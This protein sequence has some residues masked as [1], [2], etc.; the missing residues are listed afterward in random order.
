MKYIRN[1][2]TVAFLLVAPAFPAVAQ[3]S[4]SNL[5]TYGTVLTAGQWNQC[6]SQKQNYLNYTPVNK[7]GDVM[8]G[9]LTMAASTTS[10]AGITIS[11]G[12]VPLSPADGQ[13]WITTAGVYSQVNGAVWNFLSDSNPATVTNKTINCSNNTCTIPLS[14]IVTG[15]QDTVLGYF[16]STALSA[17]AVPNCTTAVIYS[18]STHTW[19]CNAAT[20]GTVTSIGLTSTYGLSVSGSP[21]TVSGNISSGVSLTTA[22]NALGADVLLNNTST[23]FDGPSMAQGTTGT[24]LVS[25]SVTVNDGSGAATIYCK[26]WDGTTVINSGVTTVS[27]TSSGSTIALSGILASPA[28]NIRISCRDVTSTNGRIFFNSTGTSRDGVISGIRIQ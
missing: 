3:S 23:Y 1:I 9:A 17:A 12:A 28:A 26:L 27:A 16:G 24:W 5:M 15:T 13:T 20:G 4:C 21:V 8:L 11:P 7:A 19:G 2:L 6:F 14:S 22:T 18:T 25:G 10:R